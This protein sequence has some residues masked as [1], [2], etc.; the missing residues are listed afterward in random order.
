M[1]DWVRRLL[2]DLGSGTDLDT[3]YSWRIVC[4][5]GILGGRNSLTIL[6]FQN[7]GVQH[8]TSP[9]S[10]G[11]HHILW[12][13]KTQFPICTDFHAIGYSFSGRF[14]KFSYFKGLNALTVQS[15]SWF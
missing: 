5:Q 3:L 11:S 1:V 7:P 6:I 10:M 2:L 13:Q 8:N 14:I 15:D 9:I 12:K 4:H